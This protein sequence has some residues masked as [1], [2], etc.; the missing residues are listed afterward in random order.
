MLHE[1][2]DAI[3]RD[4]V[5]SASGLVEWTGV[6]S[7][8]GQA[9]DVRQFFEVHNYGHI[10]NRRPI[11]LDD[12]GDGTVLGQWARSNE[13]ILYRELRIDPLWC[14]TSGL[15]LAEGTTDKAK[16]FRMFVDSPSGLGLGFTSSEGASL[17]LMLRTLHKLF[18][19][20]D[21]LDA[22]KVKVGS[23]YF[24]ELVVTGVKNG[25][26]MLRGGASG[27]GKLRTMEISL[28]IKEWALAVADDPLTDDSL[29]R[30]HYANKYSHVEPTGAG[31]ARI[32]FWCSS[33]RCRWYFPLIMYTVFG[34]IV[35]DPAAGFYR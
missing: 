8:I 17:E 14:Y 4:A 15:Y 3:L 22:W 19:G 9:I 11:R 30:R 25:V 16:L 20:F 13:T 35:A 29:L 34:E 10:A 6:P 5:Q 32:D 27:D 21:C 31:V 33:S 1:I 24:P 28:S 23:Q 7:G 2:E 18:P 26:S 12:R